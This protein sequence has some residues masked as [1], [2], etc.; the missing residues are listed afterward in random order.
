MKESK[1]DVPNLIKRIRHVTGMTQVELANEL[2][3]T[4]TSVYRYEAGT[5]KPNIS[6]LRGL[7][8]YAAQKPDLADERGVLDEIVEKRNRGLSDDKAMYDA[9][10]ATPN[11]RSRLPLQRPFLNVNVLA[12]LSDSEH[13]I[14]EAALAVYRGRDAA[15]KRM[16]EALLNPWLPQTV[17]ETPPPSTDK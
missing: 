6:V 16:L 8:A 12:S 15:A 1:I 3:I 17:Q 9:Y 7:L 14:L 10:F 2:G 4:P 11:L 13:N 5:S